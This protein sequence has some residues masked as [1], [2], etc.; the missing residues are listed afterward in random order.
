MSIPDNQI[1][2]KQLANGDQKAM[3]DIFQRFFPLVYQKIYRVIRQKE[4]SEDLAQ[5][6]FL[7]LWRK[8]QDVMIS[9]S[10]EGYL[11]TMAYHEALGH[12]R[13][14][15]P[16]RQLVQTELIAEEVASDGHLEIEGQDL[17]ERIDGVINTL[18]PRCRS[19]FVLSRFE[20][21]SY[22][23][24]SELMDISVKTVENQMIKALSTLRS[25]LKDLLTA[26]I[27]WILMQG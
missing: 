16:E 13:R 9:Q 10:L 18:P 11:A 14:K 6:V 25:S 3:R 17:Q 8:R 24:I 1:L 7:K 20:G 23:E 26:G 21:K 19:V 5:E 22:K 15:V 12:L 27:I 2:I 4:L